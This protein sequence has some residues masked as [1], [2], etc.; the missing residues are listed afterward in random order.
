MDTLVVSN[1]RLLWTQAPLKLWVQGYPFYIFKI[2]YFEKHSE[3]KI[4]GIV[5]GLIYSTLAFFRLY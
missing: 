2:H 1:I 5:I 4:S 3:F